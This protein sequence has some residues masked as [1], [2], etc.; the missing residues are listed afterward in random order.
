MADT[1]AT[2]LTEHIG[3][4]VDNDML[5]MAD[6][7]DTTMAASGTSKKN[8]AKN[9]LRTNGTAN[10]LGANLAANGYNFTGAGTVS[11]AAVLAANYYGGTVSGGTA[12]FSSTTHATKGKIIFGSV[13]YDE[14]NNRLGIG[15]TATSNPLEIAGVFEARYDANQRYAIGLQPLSGQSVIY[16]YDYT[17]SVYIPLVIDAA[18]IDLRPSG[19]GAKALSIDG[20]GNVSIAGRL[21]QAWSNVSF[22]TGW[23]DY[24]G[25]YQTAQYKKV[26]D[27]VFLRGL[28][29]RTS[30]SSTTIL[31]LPAGYRPPSQCLFPASSFDAYARIDIDTSGNVIM[32]LGSPTNWVGL[33][34]IV[35]STV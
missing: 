10:T 23:T 34:G 14:A 5:Y 15:R 2:G 30:G 24:G 1:K 33:D 4:P 19:D 31:T 21:G 12:T 20:N 32:M 28:V 8:Q 29:K 27:L 18:T 13:I 25:S 9:Y 35:F 11:T 26:G 22:N 7:S 17:G 16:A 6:V 3:P